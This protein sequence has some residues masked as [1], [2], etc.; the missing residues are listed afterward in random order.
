MCLLSPSWGQLCGAGL[1]AAIP[2]SSVALV[3]WS[4]VLGQSGS[5]CWQLPPF[6]FSFPHTHGMDRDAM[7]NPPSMGSDGEAR[8]LLGSHPP[9]LFSSC[10]NPVYVSGGW[11]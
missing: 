10:L 6:S 11:L 7:R 3:L 4:L 2:G 9:A 8:D 5:H 1:T